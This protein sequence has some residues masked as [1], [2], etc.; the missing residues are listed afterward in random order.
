MLPCCRR[1]ELPL[2]LTAAGEPVHWQGMTPEGKAMRPANL[3]QQQYQLLLPL[4]FEGVHTG[5]SDRL[6]AISAVLAR[7]RQCGCIFYL[8][9][10]KNTSLAVTSY[11]AAHLIPVAALPK[12]CYCSRMTNRAC[13]KGSPVTC[14]ACKCC[15]CRCVGRGGTSHTGTLPAKQHWTCWQLHHTQLH[16]AAVAEAPGCQALRL[17]R[18]NGCLTCCLRL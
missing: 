11:S 10:M 17:P 6:D 12:S 5:S 14:C 8:P 2:A 16:S 1:K 7:K 9:V 13:C 4:L 18:Y 15:G 3:T